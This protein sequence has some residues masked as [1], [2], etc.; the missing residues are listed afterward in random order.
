LLLRVAVDRR[1]LCRHEAGA[2]V[3]AVASK[4]ERRKELASITNSAGRYY[5]NGDSVGC[6]RQ[7]NEIADVVFA[8]MSGARETLD[9]PPIS[10]QI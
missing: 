5:W 10:S 9:R 4:G 6:G 3:D 7:E 8:R 1:F 2:H